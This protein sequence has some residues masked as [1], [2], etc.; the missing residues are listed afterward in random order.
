MSGIDLETIP[1]F[2]IS[3]FPKNVLPA[4]KLMPGPESEKIC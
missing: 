2:Y 3:F 1:D 4:R